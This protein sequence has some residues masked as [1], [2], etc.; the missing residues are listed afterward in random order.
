M[1]PQITRHKGNS[2]QD[3]PRSDTGSAEHLPNDSCR[4]D[5]DLAILLDA[6]PAL[7][8]AIKAGILAM[9]RIAMKGDSWRQHPCRARTKATSWDEMAR[10][11]QEGRD[12]G[13]TPG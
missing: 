4:T 2:S 6:W 3:L 13:P 7:P 8:G 11:I 1:R 9:V 12:N 10:F 5:R